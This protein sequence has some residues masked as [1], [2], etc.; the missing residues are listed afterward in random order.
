M[1]VLIITRSD[2]NHSIRMVSDA[3]RERGAVPIRLNSD[4]FPDQVKLATHFEGGAVS[5]SITTHEGTFD[6]EEV[7]AVW[8]RRFHAGAALPTEL[9]DTRAACVQESRRHLFGFIAALPCFHLDPIESVRRTD[10]KELQTRSAV[11]LGLDVPR[12]LFANDANA[13]REFFGACDGRIITKMQHS[14][15]IYR[16]GIENVVFTNTLEEA[17]LEDLSGLKYSPMVFQELVDKRVELRCT[18][19][20]EEVFTASIDSQQRDVTTIDWR[21]DGVGLI[22]DWQ[23][24][25]LPADIRDKLLRLCSELGL[26][27]AAAD[28]IVTPEGRHVFLEVNAVGEFFWLQ[29]SPGL[30]IV[31]AIADVLLGN[32]PRRA[33]DLGAWDNHI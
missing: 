1:T 16:E 10:H 24:Y 12:T 29:R 9:G 13:V 20:G 17:D 21:R 8:Y 7:S 33:I 27:Y 2:D 11:A 25:E 30:P 15:A 5:G 26:N 18:V 22:D 31:E 3:L 28:F 19:V 32:K 23:P 14:F 4:R 6:L